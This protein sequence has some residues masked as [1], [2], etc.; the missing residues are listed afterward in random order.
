MKRFYALLIVA[1]FAF[2]PALSAQSASFYN[3]TRDAEKMIKKM[4]THNYRRAYVG[5]NDAHINWK[6][7]DHE[8]ELIY[9]VK[10][11]FTLGYLES[12]HIY[13][14]LPLFVEYGANV[15]YLFGKEVLS[16]DSMFN[17]S[18]EEITFKANM[19]A[20]N[21]PVNA[22]FRLLFED[23]KFAVTPYVGLNLRLNLFGKQKL[24]GDIFGFEAG[25]E[26]ALFNA[27][28]NELMNANDTFK[29]FQMG[30]NYGV[31]F[32]YDVYTISVGR[33]SDFLRIAKI[34]DS[35]YKGRLG[36]T[37]ISVG[38]AF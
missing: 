1:L 34:N 11:G 15:Q 14:G 12:R 33:V 17:G 36:V 4:P 35:S 24:E 7:F 9:P 26:D 23:Y 37:T 13:D 29:R 38:Y 20:V 10:T 22:S 27:D 5:I 19:C 2:A 28:D 8:C 3:A 32:T 6:E 21:I 30:L 25:G 18:G 31:A 16:S